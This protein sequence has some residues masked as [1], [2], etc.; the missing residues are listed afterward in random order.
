MPEAVLAEKPRAARE[1]RKYLEQF[2]VEAED[3]EKLLDDFE[4]R[5]IKPRLRPVK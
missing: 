4:S 5:C 3:E 2:F 1:T